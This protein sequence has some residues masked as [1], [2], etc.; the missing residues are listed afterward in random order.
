M[1][2]A[3]SYVDANG[4]TQNVNYIA[5]AL[6]FRVAATNLPVHDVAQGVAEP[7]IAP[8]VDSYAY[9]PYAQ[10]YDY[11][12]QPMVAAAPTVAKVTPVSAPVTVPVAAPAAVPVV[13]AAP[14]VTGSQYHAQDDFGQYSFGYNDPNSQRQEIKTADGVVRG[15]YQYIDEA[16]VLQ[17]VEYVADEGGFRVAATNLPSGPAAPVVDTPEVAAAKA[18]HYAALE[19]QERSAQ[20]PVAPAVTPVAQAVAPVVQASVPIAAPVVQAAAPVV[21]VAVPAQVPATYA[22]NY[23]YTPVAPVAATADASNSQYHAQDDFGQFNYGYSNKLSTKQ[24]LKTADGV[25][26]GSYSYVD[27]NGLVQTV[28]YLSDAMGFRVAATNLP[29]HHVD[30]QVAPDA[31]VE[32][33]TDEIAIDAYAAQPQE[34]LTPSVQYSYLPYAQSYG[35]YGAASPAVQVK[36]APVVQAAAPVVQAAAPVVQA[37]APVV[38]NVVPV[39][40]V[41]AAEGSQYHAQD[42]FGQYSFGYS[43]GNSVKQEVKTADGVI[44]GAYSYVDS[45]GIVQNVN[46]IADAL[47]FRVGATNLPVHNVDAEPAAAVA[48]VAVETPE[49]AAAPVVQAYHPYASSYG[50]AAPVVQAEAPIATPVVQA[51]APV[52]TTNVDAANSQY[53][54]QDD[55]EQYNYGYSNPLSTKQE[56]KTADGVTR[57]SYSYVDANGL[58]QTVNYLS[59][60]MG[61][62]VAATNLPVHHVDAPVAKAL[63]EVS[64]PVIAPSVPYAYLPYATNYGYNVAAP[65]A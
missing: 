15:A 32:V 29:V 46:Y 40:P 38:Q 20:I 5:D 53:H 7:A 26:R 34:V 42:D 11:N 54:A 51:V 45:D 58:V 16:G 35:Y 56:L 43:D 63:E 3:Y 39:A 10:T 25:T 19:E 48:P 59:D 52:V 50:Y 18:A 4:L 44:R 17:T 13:A 55:L 36:T 14:A 2:G 64:T 49:A 1:R 33:P 37:A 30:A 60:A 24:E 22:T 12:I 23:A 47:G 21:Q 65:A 62:R 28:N 57:G 41:A 8:K 61:F 6:G 9:L 31:P 27:A